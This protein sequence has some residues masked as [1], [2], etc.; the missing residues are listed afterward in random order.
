MVSLEPIPGSV[1]NGTLR[2][3]CQSVKGYAYTHT[4]RYNLETPLYLITCFWTLWGNHSAHRKPMQ[5]QEGHVN[6]RQSGLELL[7]LEVWG[8]TADKWAPKLFK[9]AGAATQNQPPQLCAKLEL[10]NGTEKAQQKQSGCKCCALH[11]NHTFVS[12][13][14]WWIK[15]SVIDRKHSD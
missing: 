1:G 6:S 2:M 7:T 9:C 8:D 14:E 3:G 5:T 11:R 13:P 10:K 4:Q 15:L 12:C